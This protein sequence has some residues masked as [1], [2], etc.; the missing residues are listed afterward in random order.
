M[1]RNNISKLKHIISET[2]KR[3]KKKLKR[4]ALV[5]QSR[6]LTERDY[7]NGICMKNIQIDDD[8]SGGT[9][10]ATACSECPCGR[11]GGCTCYNIGRSGMAQLLRKFPT[12]FKIF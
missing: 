1:K 12:F 11:W 5:E 4:Q 10:R 7:E 3:E 8:G 2:I 6:P 9:G